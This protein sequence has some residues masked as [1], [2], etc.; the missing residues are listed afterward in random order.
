MTM[1]FR[2]QYRF[3]FL[4]FCLA[5]GSFLL[6]FFN[7][8][9]SEPKLFAQSNSSTAKKSQ[10]KRNQHNDF[11]QKIKP[12]LARYCVDCHGKEEPEGEVSL[13]GLTNREAAVKDAKTW[14][15]VLNVLKLGTMP[16][17]DYS[18]LPTKQEK[19]FVIGW[20]DVT[21]HQ[22]DCNSGYD[23]GRV[24]LRR[25]NRN[26]YNNTIRDLIGMTG[27][28]SKDFPS[29]DVGYG[30][31]NMGDVLSLPPLLM[32]KYLLAAEKITET[33]ITG[34]PAKKEKQQVY[35][36]KLQRRGSASAWRNWVA[37]SS[38]GSVTGRFHFPSS[39]E[40]HLTIEAKADQA[41]HEL[42]KM[43]LS[44]GHKKLKI[45]EVKG[46]Q[47]SAVYQIVIQADKGMGVIEARFLNDFYNPQARKRNQRDRNL[48]VRSISI[49]GPFHKNPYDHLSK[50]HQQIIFTRPTKSK[51]LKAAAREVMRRFTTR[52]YRRP[53]KEDE[54]DR[55][56]KLIE[57]TVKQ[58]ETFEQGV[59]LAMQA[60]LVSPYFLFRVEVDKTPNNPQVKHLLSDYEL[61]SRLSYFLWSSMPDEKL[62]QLASENKLHQSNVL[63]KEI[64]R[65]LRDKRSKALV[66]NFFTQWLNLRTLDEVQPDKK[67]FAQFDHS[68]R[69]AMRKE[70]EF[71]TAQIIKENR[72]IIDL[73]D[74]DYS[75]VNE[76]L[77]KHYGMKN[78]KGNHF[79]KVKLPPQRR[80]VLTQ[81]SILT[82]TSESTRTSPVKRGNWILLNILGETPPEPP[83]VVPP[84]EKAQ[85]AL[86]HASLK[87]QMALHSTD[88]A[89]AIC[90]NVMDPLGF[91]LENYDA[92]G[93]WREKD[94]KHLID[95]AGKL[96]SGET[97]SGAVEMIQIL[98]KQ[99]EGFS[100]TITRKLLIYALGRGLS[101]YDRCVIDDIT[102]AMKKEDYRFETLV[103]QII[104]S[105]PFL[106]R[107]GERKNI[108]PKQT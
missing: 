14:D 68:L 48:F 12:I 26:E 21:F 92:I 64:K 28:F 39:G 65:M 42:A 66:D 27:D 34:E 87:M 7:E 13:A 2:H 75:F 9:T 61:A 4:L 106:M 52:A 36:N 89:C 72:S 49:E 3:V 70:T 30:F 38:S 23:P 22:V 15:K 103:T 40:Y 100:R 50:Q 29:D 31:D 19:Q 98:R 71:F 20:V 57:T 81:A 79:R 16:P 18:P 83:A 93:H 59:Q 108:A 62:L 107:R 37:M 97:Y 53:V 55:L 101:P 44:L 46:N 78:I 1:F 8:V 6:F 41:G 73:L 67:K 54:L 91:G 94:G 47:K 17:S 32:E 76:R 85:K 82:L 95:A 45:I 56:V 90:H 74:A 86:P 104:L 25:L 84:L 105:K 69:K 80:G 88:P 60:V 11:Q 5:G 43:G 58:G 77:A 33:A 24:T 99:K 51:K 102:K 63:K 96:P 10:K 35:A